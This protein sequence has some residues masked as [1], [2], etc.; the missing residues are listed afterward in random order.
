MTEQGS[1]RVAASVAQV[2][3]FGESTSKLSSIMQENTLAVRQ[4]SVAV[5][6]QNAGITQ[7]FQAINELNTSMNETMSRVNETSTVTSNVQTVATRV[8]QLIESYGWEDMQRA[9]SNK[10]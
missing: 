10:R 8:S 9:R 6:Q 2:K 1:D 7:I 5:S 4:I 3:A